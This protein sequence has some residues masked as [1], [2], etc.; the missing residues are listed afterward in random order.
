MKLIG[1]HYLVQ[2]IDHNLPDFLPLWFRLKMAYQLLV[3]VILILGPVVLG[4]NPR[5]VVATF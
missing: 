1:R 4:V 3:P 2:P 5:Q